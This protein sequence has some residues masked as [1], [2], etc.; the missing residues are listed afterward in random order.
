MKKLRSEE[1][2]I[3]SPFF[4]KKLQ[5]SCPNLFGLLVVEVT[6]KEIIH[7][8][9]WHI[10]LKNHLWFSWYGSVVERGPPNQ[11]VMV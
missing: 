3:L 9:Y 1:V 6:K 10:D 11:E 7:K 5:I 2:E 4:Q 8:K